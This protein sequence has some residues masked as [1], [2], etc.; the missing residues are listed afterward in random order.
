MAS[1]LLWAMSLR[2]LLTSARD[3]FKW[4]YVKADWF[5]ERT[6]LFETIECHSIFYPDPCSA[7]ARMLER[8]IQSCSATDTRRS[9]QGL[10]EAFK[11]GWLTMMGPGQSAPP[12]LT[13][14]THGG[15]NLISKDS[16][17]THQFVI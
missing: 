13:L 12:L 8:E 4:T 7:D 6:G 9:G 3:P 1:A 11:Q 5:L 14:S 2:S 10:F 15:P 17:L 16:G